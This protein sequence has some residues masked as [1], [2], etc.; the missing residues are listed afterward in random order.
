MPLELREW[1]HVDLRVVLSTESHGGEAY[2][3]HI[4][5]R[6]TE[7]MLPDKQDLVWDTYVLCQRQ[8]RIVILQYKYFVTINY[9][10]S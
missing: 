9:F 4:S 2:A 6:K 10:D 3:L 5:A 1:W 7:L 8:V